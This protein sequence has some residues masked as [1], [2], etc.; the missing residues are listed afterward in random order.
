MDNGIGG[1][2]TKRAFLNGDKTAFMAGELPFTYTDVERRTNKLG[3]AL[4]DVGVRKGDRVA[5]LL[6]NSVEFM[7]LLIAAA[8]IGAILVPINVRLGA[9]E[10]SYILADSGADTFVVH[11]PLAAMPWM[12]VEAHDR[13]HRLIVDRLQGA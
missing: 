11:Q 1:W 8:K 7:E 4:L 5:A 9:G 2:V 6:F 12:D 10:I 3:S 13:P